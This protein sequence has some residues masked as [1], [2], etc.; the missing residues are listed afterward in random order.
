MGADVH[1]FIQ[2]KEKSDNKEFWWPFG[3]KINPGR[4]Y[5][6]FGILAGVRNHDAPNRFEPKGILPK[7]KRSWPVED[8]LYLTITEDGTGD[9]E[10]TLEAAKRWFGG[11]EIIM[12]ENGKPYKVLH[13]DWHSHSWMTPDELEQA[14]KNYKKY[15]KRGGYNKG[16]PLEYKVILK[17]M[18][19]LEDKGKNEVLLVFWFDN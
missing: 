15:A 1:M 13:P 10:T 11:K 5:A 3:S 8:D 12:D 7:E 6:M 17:T 18:R 14:Y 9:H 16:V 4:N 19:A 2:Y